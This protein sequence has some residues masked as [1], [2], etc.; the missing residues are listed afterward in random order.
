MTTTL[1][2]TTFNEFY[3]RFSEFFD[4][5]KKCVGIWD[6]IYDFFYDCNEK[7][8]DVGK[9]EPTMV[10]F[11]QWDH[12]EYYDAS[13]ENCNE[14]GEKR[15]ATPGAVVNGKLVTTRLQDINVGIEEF[16]EHSYY[17]SWDEYPYKTD[18]LGAPL[19]PFIHGIKQ[20][21]HDQINKTGKKSIVGQQPQHGIEMFLRQEH[22][23][24]CIS[25]RYQISYQSEYFYFNWQ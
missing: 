21:Y 17:E 25:L 18:P 12:E 7:Y 23:Q 22:M 9:L 13:Y 4:Y 2:T 15:W 14:W 10:D 11:G 3:I 1:S 16:I 20:L 6:D 8:M 5:S 19:S 24:E